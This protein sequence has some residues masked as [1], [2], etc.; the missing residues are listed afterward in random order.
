MD[1]EKFDKQA[2]AVVQEAQ[3]L[4]IKAGNPEL[5][6]LHLHAALIADDK[7]VVV[8]AL[9][10]M[11]IDLTAYRQAVDEELAKLP[12]QSGKSQTYISTLAR[13]ILLKSEDEA[14][15][16]ESA[17][18]RA[19][20]IY[21]ALLAE[22]DTTSQKIFRKFRIKRADFLQAL[23]DFRESQRN[24]PQLSEENAEVLKNFGRDLTEE[25]KQGKLDPVIGRDEEIRDCIRILSRRKKNNPVLI[26]EPGVGKTAVVEGLAQRIVHNDV[27]QPLQDKRIW[28]LDLG[29]LVAG[30]KYRGEFE[31]RLKGVLKAIQDSYGQIILF[32]DEM[33]TLVGAGQA[34]GSLDASNMMKPML[35]RGEIKVIGATT[36]NEYRESIE[37]DGAL[38][39][40]FQ[41]VLIQEPGV[42]DTVS[43][44][45]GIKDKYEIHHGIRISDNAVVA[46]ARLS[47]RYISDR[48][49]PDKAIDLVDEAAAMVRT[50]IDTMPEELDEMRRRILQMQIEI[51]ALKKEDDVYSQERLQCLE[52]ERSNLQAEFDGRF[53]AWEAEKKNIDRVKELKEEIDQ[54]KTEM[55]EAERNYDFER[56]SELKY[57][58]LA[59]LETEL[60]EANKKAEEQQGALKEEVDEEDIAEVVAK[61]T[62]I[63]VNKLKQ[64]DRDKV[65]EL[66]EILRKRVVGQEEAVEAISNA[67]IRS[68]SGLKS[69]RKPI[70][71]FIFLGP[72]GVGKTE[73]AKTLTKVLFDD[74][75]N[76][77]RIDMSEYM[78]KYN[79]S[80]LIGAAPGYIGYDEGGQ[81]T[82]QVRRRPYSVILFDE[83]EKAHPDVFNILLQVLDDGRLTDG[84]GR[85][86]D[87][88]NT[89]I[90]M[91]SN[92]GSNYLMSGIDAQG[93][94]KE[95]AAE[96]VKNEMHR[97]FRPEFLNRIDEIVL[98]KPLGEKEIE[99]ILQIQIGDLNDRLAEQRINIELSEAAKE[100]IVQKGFSVQFGARSLKRYLEGHLETAIGR[101]ILEGK[102]YRDSKVL[103]ETDEY[104]RFS[105]V[106]NIGGDK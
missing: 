40:R 30:S 95:S 54:V 32:I 43:I 41:R 72:T 79:V 85:T 46:A 74:E 13:R 87:F 15:E 4:A 28:S 99:K 6:D 83:I 97:H 48:F 96:A 90:I 104:G 63:P 27:P 65:L 59:Q 20:H 49:L 92:I 70:G 2:L 57:R 101:A 16:A 102:I 1:L 8:S 77:I 12:R 39:R 17:A 76:M 94:I 93:E 66:P 103:V 64:S 44:L 81:L 53:A 67:I 26:G 73:L 78:E 42:E 91:T 88:K 7:S 10:R 38:E 9:Q 56:L 75:R 98:F 84:Q 80:R 50:E 61:L 22:E 89:V 47:D 106:D 62:G 58:R 68:R 105:F 29:S 25:A 3:N 35:A 33:H 36:L 52:E 21:L 69:D 24:N 31:E 82:E 60:A 5:D 86:I 18:V 11:N 14:K 34:E 51:A 55:A 45:R 37:K 19:K 23:A 100:L 71:S